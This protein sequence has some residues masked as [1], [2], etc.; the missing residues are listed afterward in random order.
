MAL[1]DPHGMFGGDRMSLL[2]DSAKMA[3]PWF[4]CASNTV[5]RLELDYNKICAVAFRQFQNRP[6][7]DQFWSWVSEFKDA[8]LLFVYESD[9]QLWGQWDTS[10]KWLPSYKLSGDLRSPAP[11]AR[12][13]IEWRNSYLQSKKTAAS[14]KLLRIN[15]SVKPSKDSEGFLPEPHGVGVGVGVGNGVGEAHKSVVRAFPSK[16]KAVDL[17]G[18][19]SQRFDEFWGKYPRKVHK[20]QACRAWVSYVTADREEIVFAALARYLDSDEVHRSVVMNPENWLKA[21]HEDNWNGDWPG[22]PSRASP[23]TV[24]GKK[25]LAEQAKEQGDDLQRRVAEYEQRRLQPRS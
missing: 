9:G 7:E 14:S 19:V 1:I 17:D 10:E 24:T 23:G 13:F 2:S 18:L 8:F 12:D 16:P 25:T 11:V 6:T 4:W 5:G 3:W 22:A 15:N 21:Q 20:D